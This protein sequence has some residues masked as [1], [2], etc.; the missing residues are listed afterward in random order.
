MGHPVAFP[1]TLGKLWQ[2]PI[3]P[4]NPVH[5]I[6]TKHMIAITMHHWLPSLWINSLLVSNIEIGLL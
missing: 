4:I 2:P 6:L 1:L 5:R 3:D